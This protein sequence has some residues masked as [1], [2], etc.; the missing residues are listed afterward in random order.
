MP[1]YDVLQVDRKIDCFNVEE[2]ATF[3]M[4]NDI[5]NLAYGR[6]TLVTLCTPVTSHRLKALLRSGAS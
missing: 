5:R 6:A 1:A 4:W 2:A 3:Q